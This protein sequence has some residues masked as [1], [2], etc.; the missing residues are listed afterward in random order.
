MEKEFSKSFYMSAGECDARRQMPVH[1]LV[2]RIIEVA[3][4]HANSWGVG[5]RHLI[6]SGQGWVLSRL[7]LEMDE[8]PQ[9]DTCYSLTTWIESYNRHY[10]QR[11]VMVTDDA[12]GRVLGYART[13]WMVIDIAARTGVDISELQYISA[14]VN[15]RPCPIA[16]QSRLR[17]IAAPTRT[18]THTVTYTDCDFYRHMNTV[19]YVELLMNQFPL[20]FHDNNVVRRLE[21]VF[22]AETRYG[23]ALSVL[24]DESEPLD[25]KAQ[26]DDADGAT[27]LRARMVFL[28]SPSP[29]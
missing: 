12:T 29:S 9:V 14:N 25:V 7:T 3:T 4:L 15:D 28:S 17:P 22:S 20:S 5:Y 19:R 1:L 2:S 11:C 8:W 21:L 23:T 16:P 24:L 10:S 27:H 18:A 26:L 6:E 13:I